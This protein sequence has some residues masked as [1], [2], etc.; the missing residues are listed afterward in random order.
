MFASGR[1]KDGLLLFLDQ[2][3]LSSLFHPTGDIAHRPRLSPWMRRNHHRLPFDLC[4]AHGAA[5]WTL[6][7]LNRRLQQTNRLQLNGSR[8]RTMRGFPFRLPRSHLI[9]MGRR[10]A[11]TDLRLASFPI[12]GRVE[13]LRCGSRIV[14]LRDNCW[15]AS[16][17]RQ[18]G[19]LPIGVLEFCFPTSGISTYARF[20]PVLTRKAAVNLWRTKRGVSISSTRATA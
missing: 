12:D 2:D 10:L 1:S 20:S 9:P 7:L 3:P 5:R 6:H 17:V 18:V 11:D 15:H 8:E 14:S 13:G 4:L 16:Q 19:V